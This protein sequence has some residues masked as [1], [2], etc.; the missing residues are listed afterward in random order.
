[1]HQLLALKRGEGETEK[2]KG[3]HEEQKDNAKM[4]GNENVIKML[5]GW[6][7]NPVALVVNAAIK[8]SSAGHLVKIKSTTT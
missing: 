8:N 4:S 1:M 5:R 6:P 2:T 7:T 3:R